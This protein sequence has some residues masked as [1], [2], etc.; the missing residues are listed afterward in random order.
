MNTYYYGF[1]AQ[2]ET[3]EDVG[4][5]SKLPISKLSSLTSSFK[6]SSDSLHIAMIGKDNDTIKSDL[7]KGFDEGKLRMRK[8]IDRGT[9]VRKPSWHVVK[10]LSYRNTL[11]PDFEEIRFGNG[12]IVPAELKFSTSSF[13]YH[14]ISHRSHRQYL[15]EKKNGLIVVSLKHDHMPRG[16]SS[17]KLDVWELDYSDFSSWCRINFD[18]LLGRQMNVHSGN[19][20]VYVMMPGSKNFY[21]VSKKL[22]TVPPAIESEIWC[23]QTTYTGYDLAEGDIVLFVKMK[24]CN[25]VIVQPHY[26]SEGER[27]ASG[28]SRR[29][30]VSRNPPLNQW[31]IADIHVCEVTSEIMSRE[32]YCDINS[33]DRSTQLWVQDPQ[34]DG[35]WRWD[36]VFEFENIKQINCNVEVAKLYN[37]QIG[38]N[39]VFTLADY[40]RQAGGNRFE[41]NNDEY[42]YLLQKLIPES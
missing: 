11:F 10:H 36:R 37:R 24:G 34:N 9:I 17:E 29:N 33:L 28:G 15:D 27:L 32:E 7:I 40:L 14:N 2:K 4:E 18:L 20:R 35:K 19:R 8:V 13:G 31:R 30:W 16:F 12:P 42:I 22:Q 23:P 3:Y 21:P 39:L 26:I 41:I 6:F 25:S 5:V 1:R 38:H